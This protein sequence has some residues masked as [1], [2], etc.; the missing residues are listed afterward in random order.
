[1]ATAQGLGAFLGPL[2]G[3]YLWDANIRYPFFAA[4]ALL[5]LSAL[6][7]LLFIHVPAPHE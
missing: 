3:G 4:A 6:I 2:A 5:T 1:M 7:A